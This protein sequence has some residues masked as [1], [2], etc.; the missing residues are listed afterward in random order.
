M[1]W[2]LILGAKSDIAKAVA[3][4]FGKNGFNLYLAARDHDELESDVNDLV[5]RYRIKAEAV[6]FNAL[7]LDSHRE[8]YY[9][10]KEK[11]LGVIC[12]VGYLGD[13]KKAE[14]DFA[15]AKKIIDT[16]YTGCASIFNIIANDFKERREGFIIGISSAAGGRG[17]QSNYFYGSAKAALTAYLS[18]LRNRLSR[19]NVQV[20]TIKPGFVNTKMTE[21]MRLPPLLVSQPEEV[22]GDIFNAYRKKKDMVY[23]K[24][25]WK[26]IMAIIK[27]IPERIFKKMGL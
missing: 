25:F 27:N 21:G 23:T 1:A 4:K 19:S 8:F 13:Q 26:W 2:L 5:I 14:Q 6:E 7:N 16:N 20:V 15:E 10:L 9:S 11:P 22:A 12:A 18:G 3:H 24:W 17:R